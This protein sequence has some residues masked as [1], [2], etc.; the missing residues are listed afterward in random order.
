MPDQRQDRHDTG[1]MHV[2]EGRVGNPRSIV[3]EVEC[4]WDE[5]AQLIPME[6]E[7]QKGQM[8]REQQRRECE[9]KYQMGRTPRNHTAY[10]I[11]DAGFG[12]RR[13]SPKV[14]SYWLTFWFSTF[15]RALACCGLKKTP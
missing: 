13:I 9:E 14:A 3:I 8:H 5:L 15:A 12:S 2:R 11:D 1:W 10:W 7:R 6:R 4:G